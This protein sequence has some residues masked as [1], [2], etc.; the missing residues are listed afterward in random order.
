ME[1]ALS[2]AV[3]HVPSSSFLRTAAGYGRAVSPLV[4]TANALRPLSYGEPL[5]AWAFAAGWHVSELPLFTLAGQLALTARASRG[6]RWRTGPGL[7][8][9][10]AQ[11]G[12]VA[13]LVSLQRSAAEAKGVLEAALEEG[14][15]PDYPELAA[16]AV[17]G[18][19]EGPEIN[20]WRALPTWLSRRGRMRAEGVLYGPTGSAT[21]ST[22]GRPRTSALVTGR[23]CWCRSLG[24]AG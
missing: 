24:A 8:R 4:F 18:P 1:P 6:G 10:A 21:V 23:R 14:L 19:D 22:S 7:V 17:V 2:C 3:P 15:G 12:S 20:P 13:G 16:R 5:G 11:A 9:L